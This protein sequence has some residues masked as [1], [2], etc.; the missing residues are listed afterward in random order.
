MFEILIAVPDEYILNMARSVRMKQLTPHYYGCY[1]LYNI[2]VDHSS[3][4]TCSNN[5]QIEG[6]P[7]VYIGQKL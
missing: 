6:V 1:A 2:I 5:N 7:V 3:F 4:M